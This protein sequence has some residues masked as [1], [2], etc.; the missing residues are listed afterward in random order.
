M[1]EMMKKTFDEDVNDALQ[2]L[3]HDDANNVVEKV[4]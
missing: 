3:Y 2:I 1:L 4:A